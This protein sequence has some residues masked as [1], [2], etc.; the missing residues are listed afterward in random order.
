MNKNLFNM[1]FRGYFPKELPPAFNTY[2][3][4]LDAE[5]IRKTLANL[6]T[7]RISEPSV[8]SIPKN[9]IGRR[10]ISIVNPYSFYNLASL[11]TSDAIYSNLQKVCSQSKISSSEPRRCE[12]LNKRAIIP[13]C[14]SVSDF[15]TIKLYRGLYKRVEL[16]IDISCFYSTIY[17]HAITWMTVGKEKAKDIWRGSLSGSSYSC[18]DK[19]IDNLY[20]QANQIDKLVECCQDKQTHG[21]PVGPDTSF[22]IAE[23][24]LC[25]IDG[26]IEKKFPHIQGCRYYDDWFLYVDSQDEAKQLLRIVI[27]ELEKFGL[28]VNL[29]KVEINEMPVAVLD[30]FADRL[31]SFDFHNASNFERIKVFFEVLWSLIRNGRNRAATFTRYAMRVLGGFMTPAVV[32]SMNKDN[33]EMI[34]IMLFRT[35]ADLPE[36]IPAILP[37]LRAMGNLP[38]NRKMTD[39]ID[40]ILQ[41]HVTLDHHI[42]VAWALWMCKIYNI[43]ITPKRV[44]EIFT[45]RNPVCSLLLLDY[46]HNVNPALLSDNDVRNAVENLRDSLSDSSLYDKD[47]LLLYEGVRKGWLTGIDNL[48]D[49]DP[50]FKELRQRGVSFYDENTAADYQS[51]S[52]LLASA[53]RLPQ[54]VKDEIEKMTKQVTDGVA[55]AV[56]KKHDESQNS[57]PGDAASLRIDNML[58]TVNDRVADE[59]LR[60]VLMEEKVDVPKL[61]AKYTRLV[62][63]VRM[64]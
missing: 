12:Y 9:G 21:I 11:L 46:V 55:D 42:E 10:K 16:K 37:V 41:R 31:S 6:W 57:A 23:T 4:A 19:K 54:H 28:D 52:Y 33:K 47:W 25:H 13:K 24:L 29:S 48:V 20:Q 51:H 50:F 34:R 14:K 38:D 22:L 61:K 36:C 43:L 35:V 63:S 30:D 7:D 64:S 39:L 62:R 27:E 2:D 15:Q 56:D 1:L 49:N 45:T 58:R 17:T 5:N 53:K 59:V 32:N 26:N 8:F 60:T 18:G 44:V 3:F 40:S